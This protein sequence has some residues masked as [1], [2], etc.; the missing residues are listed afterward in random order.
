MFLL[1][2]HNHPWMERTKAWQK[3]VRPVCRNCVEMDLRNRIWICEKL[4]FPNLTKNGRNL[5]WRNKGVG[6]V[7]SVC[8]AAATSDRKTMENKKSGRLFRSNIGAT[9]CEHAQDFM[10]KLG[11]EKSSRDTRDVLGQIYPFG[12]SQQQPKMFP[13]NKNIN[14]FLLVCNFIC[15]CYVF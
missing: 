12:K 11:L 14:T 10:D 15:L 9:L 6:F 1:D 3:K 2:F 8:R 13:H 7:A 4:G 5:D